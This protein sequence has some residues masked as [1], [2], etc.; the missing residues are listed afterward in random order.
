[1][2]I[3]SPHSQRQIATLHPDLRMIHLRVIDWYD[4]RLEY[5]WRDADTQ[6]RLFELGRSNL[7]WPDSRHNH[8]V[9][10]VVN[11][12]QKDVPQSLA[13]DTIPWVREYGLRIWPQNDDPPKVYLDKIKHF[14]HFA[15]VM[16]AVARELRKQGLIEHR[17]R[18]GGDWDG[19][20]S[21]TDQKLDDLAHYELIV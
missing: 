8:I 12:E 9:S 16:Q 2:G 13:A 3:Y 19:D 18:W 17:L 20:L 7:R 1:M 15:G 5:G 10:K 11:G 4:H 21:F 6:N 14:V